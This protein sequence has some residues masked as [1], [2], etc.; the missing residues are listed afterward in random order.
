MATNKTKKETRKVVLDFVP[1]S[2]TKNTVVFAECTATGTVKGIKE[3]LVGRIY[4][5]HN[6]AP[7]FEDQGIKL[8]EPDEEGNQY[9]DTNKMRVTI[10]LMD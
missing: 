1:D 4:F 7:G 6:S 9:L 5:K 8:S 10:E 2:V 3:S